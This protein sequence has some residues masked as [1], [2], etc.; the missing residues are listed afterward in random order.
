MNSE[1]AL[2]VV[3]AETREDFRQFWHMF[4]NCMV[5]MVH[6]GNVDDAMLEWFLSDGY[7]RALGARSRSAGRPRWREAGGGAWIGFCTC[8]REA[9]RPRCCTI[10]T[11]FLRG[12]YRGRGLGCDAWK[13]IEQALFQEGVSQFA[14]AESC[15]NCPSFWAANGFRQTG[16]ARWEK[17]RRKRALFLF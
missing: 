14:T 7:R 1:R 12:G 2:R 6:R 16:A 11:F 5:E 17:R 15:G 10:T 3:P 13:Q 9:N 4:D 8:T